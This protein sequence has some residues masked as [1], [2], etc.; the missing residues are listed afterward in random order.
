MEQSEIG[1]GSTT[2]IIAAAS[3]HLPVT[4]AFARPWAGNA[5]AD[6]RPKY[7]RKDFNLAPPLS[8]EHDYCECNSRNGHYCIVANFFGGN[9]AINMNTVAQCGCGDHRCD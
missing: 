7:R 5:R 3:R 2:A 9:A 4:E 1:L 8:S 6:C